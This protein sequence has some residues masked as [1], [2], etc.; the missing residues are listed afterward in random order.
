M[1]SYQ[2][3]P[4]QLGSYDVVVLGGGI[5]GVF[6]AVSA[7]REGAKVI[8]CEAMGCLGGTMT[9]GL[10]TQILDANNKGGLI[11]ELYDALGPISRTS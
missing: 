3:Q 10:V 2:I 8:L 1:R 4:K 6:A 5:A 9:S 7:A 11:R